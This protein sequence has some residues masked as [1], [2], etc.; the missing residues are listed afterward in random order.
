MRYKV[1][2]ISEYATDDLEHPWNTNYFWT[3]I[4]A[5]RCFWEEAKYVII[6]KR[7]KLTWK[8]WKYTDYRIVKQ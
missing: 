7:Y 1:V 2:K 6:V 3:S 5:T 4:G 8:G